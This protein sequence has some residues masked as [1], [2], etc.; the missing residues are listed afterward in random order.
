MTF[1]VEERTGECPHTSSNNVEPDCR[2][3]FV[4]QHMAQTFMDEEEDAILS[5]KIR[6][7]EEAMS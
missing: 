3:P 2:T 5:V 4:N 6:T 1:T 7:D